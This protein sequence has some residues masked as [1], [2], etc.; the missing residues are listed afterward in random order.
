M[1]T[2]PR[3]RQ[4][5]GVEPLKNKAENEILNVCFPLAEQHPRESTPVRCFL[6]CALKF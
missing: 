3:L 1:R 4:T 6:Q 2:D 5:E